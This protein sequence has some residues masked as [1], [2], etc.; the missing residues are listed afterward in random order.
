MPDRPQTAPPGGCSDLVAHLNRTDRSPC[1]A[2][3][4]RPWTGDDH[5]RPPNH[6]TWSRRRTR[7]TPVHPTANCLTELPRSEHCPIVSPNR[8]PDPTTILG[9]NPCPMP[10]ARRPTG[11]RRTNRNLALEM[12]RGS[13]EVSAES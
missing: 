9:W 5:D 2:R 12:D 11:R 6:P 8:P 7:S 10:S 13:T 1:C 3:P 4:R